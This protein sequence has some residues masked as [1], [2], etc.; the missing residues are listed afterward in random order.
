V[1]EVAA[2]LM[3]EMIRPQFGDAPPYSRSGI[4]RAVAMTFGSRSWATVPRVA[5]VS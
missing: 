1:D 3:H 5:A 2:A 4:G